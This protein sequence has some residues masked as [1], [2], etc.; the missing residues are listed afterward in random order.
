MGNHT[1][2]GAGAAA[3]LPPRG[4]TPKLSSATAFPPNL[5]SAPL[6]PSAHPTA[7]V[8]SHVTTASSPPSFPPPS[9]SP[10]A[11][12]ML[13]LSLTGGNAMSA[14]ER[15]RISRERLQAAPP[16][17]RRAFMGR[18]A[19]AQ[20]RLAPP[21]AVAP[22]PLARC[23]VLSAAARSCARQPGVQ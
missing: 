3:N 11:P 16:P 21:G 12:R 6:P 13:A 1:D 7:H 18:R 9:P 20:R 5:L 4:A 23:A 2:R 10:P 19:C 8:R 17:P 15:G 14:A 22:R